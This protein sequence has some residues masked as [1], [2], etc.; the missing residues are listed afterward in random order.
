MKIGVKEIAEK[1]G[2]STATVSHALN[3]TRYVSPELAARVQKIADELGYVAKHSPGRNEKQ[4]RVGKMSEIALIIPDTF[5]VIYNRLIQILT[6]RCE[7]AG[8]SLATYLSNSNPSMEKHLLSEIISNRRIAGLILCP[9]A[10]DTKNYQKLIQSEK[11]FICLERDLEG[12][13]VNS[14]V[15]NNM[16]GVKN[17]IEHLIK[18]GHEKI[19]MLVE[20][21]D[22]YTISERKTGYTLALKDYDIP[23]DEQLIHSISLDDEYQTKEQIKS[24]IDTYNPTAILAAGNTLTLR[25]LKAIDELGL[26]C[27]KD[28]SVVGFGDN[29]W[30]TLINPP[31]TTLT[32]NTEELGRNAI[33]ILMRK[34]RGKAMLRKSCRYQWS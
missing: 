27:P 14:V 13:P 29:E 11:P 24:F 30:C 21:K 1:S 31:L 34:L 4:Y 16:Q 17:G 5:S 8:Y 6:N 9:A 20:D 23:Y 7:E 28:I 26:Y 2:V 18:C 19:G 25:A 10:T 33:S 3:K 22:L 15:S 12:A 32:Q